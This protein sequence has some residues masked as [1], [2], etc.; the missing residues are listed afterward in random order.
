M[1]WDR[2]LYHPI[3]VFP[4]YCICAGFRDKTVAKI[5]APFDYF[6][7]INGHMY[8][9]TEIQQRFTE[10][11]KQRMDEDESY[12]KRLLEEILQ[13]SRELIQA[14]KRISQG[15]LKSMSR[16]ELRE[17]LQ[18][19][20]DEFKDL[21]PYLPTTNIFIAIFEELIRKELE[22]KV[23]SPELI[24]DYIL[25]LASPIKYSYVG[26]FYRAL[27]ELAVEMHRDDKCMNILRE[28]QSLL[29]IEKGL[30]EYNREVF[31]AIKRLIKNFS[32]LNFQF[33]F[34]QV[35]TFED[36][37]EKLR[38]LTK[39]DPVIKLQEFK[40]RKT[41]LRQKRWFL[42]KLLSNKGASI[43]ELMSE[44]ALVRQERF[45]AFNRAGFL[46]RALFEE[47][48]N[49]LGLIYS[50]V[51]YL[52]PT[53]LLEAL[54]SSQPGDEQLREKA[55]ERAKGYAM[56]MERGEIRLYSGAQMEFIVKEE[57]AIPIMS[58]VRG[59][60]ASRG[61]AVGEA[62]VILDKSDFNKIQE[63]DILVVTATTPEYT[64]ILNK[65]AAIVADVGGVTSHTAFIAREMGIPCVTNTKIGTKIFKDG[66]LVEVDAIRGVVKK[67]ALT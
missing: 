48:A 9:H 27:L 65:V 45:E 12:P 50:E 59:K 57:E 13:E 30:W 22:Q 35:L 29:E 4:S 37:L 64:L 24:Q 16:L 6:K 11:L 26:R 10:Y 66:D 44:F 31:D 58:E 20:V 53:E 62:R 2:R 15:D 25:A 54:A 67:L 39:F 43:A 18:E 63:G 36:I 14:A 41:E 19:F 17:A 1:V 40:R 38:G 61:V 33:G 28:G 49:R 46:A 7:N 51:S 52:T 42:K 8:I 56:V 60:V 34:G 55:V 5:G 32:W 23:D 21:V 3:P 47:V